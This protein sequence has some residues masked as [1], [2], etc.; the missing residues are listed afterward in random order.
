VICESSRIAEVWMAQAEV[1][2]V[3][4]LAALLLLA[5]LLTSR[6]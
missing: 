3:L 1:P 6:V 4:A 2:I 5:L